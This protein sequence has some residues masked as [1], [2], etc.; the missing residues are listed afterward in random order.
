MTNVIAREQSVNIMRSHEA[1]PFSARL[2]QARLMC[3]LSLRELA[4]K[5]GGAVSYAAL[6]K[7]EHGVMQP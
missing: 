4:D 2:K 3:G 7:Y 5:I 1:S 6:S